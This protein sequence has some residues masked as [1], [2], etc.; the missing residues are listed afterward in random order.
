M[1][2]NGV[3]KQKG[4]RHFLPKRLSRMLGTKGAGHLFCGEGDGRRASAAGERPTAHEENCLWLLTFVP[5]QIHRSPLQG[6][7]ARRRRQGA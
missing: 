1:R 3:G 6:P 2:K 4:D 5:D 7:L